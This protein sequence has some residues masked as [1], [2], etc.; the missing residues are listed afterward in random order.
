[1][2]SF[3]Y[4]GSIDSDI[5]YQLATSSSVVGGAG[6]GNLQRKGV[7]TECLHKAIPGAVHV[8][9][10]LYVERTW[11]GLGVRR[12]A[13]QNMTLPPWIGMVTAAKLRKLHLTAGG[14]W[15]RF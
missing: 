6:T 10:I 4:L 13:R 5:I 8:V 15:R 7:I 3:R 2:K 12:E 1:M 11:L 14:I 9:T